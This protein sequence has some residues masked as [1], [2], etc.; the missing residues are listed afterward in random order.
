MIVTRPTF[1]IG[2]NVFIK[3]PTNRI[4]GE[5][6]VGPSGS[7]IAITSK[8]FKNRQGVFQPGAPAVFIGAGEFASSSTPFLVASSSVG[9]VFSISDRLYAQNSGSQF[10]V[11]VSGTILV[12]TQPNQ[13]TDVRN[14]IFDSSSLMGLYAIETAT[15]AALS[16][17]LYV[18]FSSSLMTASLTAISSALAQKEVADQLALTSS[19]IATSAS[20]ISTAIA[21][22][23]S[24]ASALTAVSAAFVQTTSSIAVVDAANK[25]ILS[26]STKTDSG[27]YLESS[28]MG[29][30]NSA[31]S[32]YPVVIN[33]IG[34]FR[35]ANSASFVG[36][37]DPYTELVG[38]AN[39]AF[40]V[41]TGK[42]MLQTPTLQLLGNDTGSATANVF[43]IGSNVTNIS[44]TDRLGFYVDGA[45]NFRVGTDAT[46]SEFFQFSPS[47]GLVIK[48]K[49]L[50]LDAG[51]IYATADTSSASSGHQLKIGV[52]AGGLTFSS[53]SGFYVDGAGNIRAGDPS[54][55]F[56]EFSP[57]NAF[58]LKTTK[59]EM[60]AT[61]MYLLAHPA[62]GSTNVI[63]LAPAASGVT[64]TKNKGF[65]VDGDG[66]F[67][68]GTDITGSNYILLDSSNALFISASNFFLNAGSG[69]NNVQINQ[70]QM[71]LGNSTSPGV[72]P[73]PYNSSTFKG[74]Y[75]NNQG[76]IFV[77]DATQ[78]YF[79]FGGQ[80][81]EIKSNAFVLKTP[82]F[83]FSSSF[84]GSGGD[85][86]AGSATALNT[87]TGGWLG[88]DGS[89][90]AGNPAGGYV[91]WNGSTLDVVGSITV[92]GG[93]ASTQTYANSAAATAQSNAQNFAT[94]ADT[95]LSSS[96]ASNIFT[97][98][99]GSIIKAPS[100]SGTGLFLGST[101]MGYYTGGAWTT[102]FD[103]TGNFQFKGDGSNLI[104]WNGST[105]TVKANTLDVN[106]SNFRLIANSSGSS[107]GIG[108]ATAF[109]GA[110]LFID[111]TGKFICLW[112]CWRDWLLIE[113]PFLIIPLPLFGED[114]M[115]ISFI[116]V[117]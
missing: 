36:G 54:T 34:Q 8:G 35:F 56:I 78:N 3:G 68:V 20:I 88:G 21:Y 15:N 101:N 5:L 61:G 92:T 107:M 44:L 63:K 75:A 102:Y 65:Y 116:L 17:S 83:Q 98:T 1:F 108:G 106:A 31:Q 52:N 99:A 100:P 51:G 53:G 67:R 29:F 85:L 28:S 47:A 39:G 46:G 76:Q 77:G 13:F 113:M 9:P 41:R 38:F 94:S 80:V 91:R 4:D 110:G 7:S 57:S 62:S 33:S 97:N 23:A 19:I 109:V 104:S 79:Q 45:G 50:V 114:W 48:A 73:F 89:F 66:N 16:A 86:R 90:R 32:Q 14:L 58:R 24:L 93:D 112:K 18:A 103:N 82:G 40:L 12:E 71:I 64:L 10:I 111:N 25:I 6:V 49:R 43:R 96:V 60:D 105:F 55:S 70:F 30:Y 72:W 22:S 59:L 37:A 26:T 115:L 81:M 74:F 69:G 95:T 27:L 84:S 2:E 11:T 87:G 117:I 42:L